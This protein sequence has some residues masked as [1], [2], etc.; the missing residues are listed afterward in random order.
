MVALSYTTA[1]TT[2]QAVIN[3]LEAGISDS[4]RVLKFADDTKL[5]RKVDSSND[6]AVLQR[7]GN[8]NEKISKI[9]RPLILPEVINR[10]LKQFTDSAET[11]KLL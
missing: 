9:G 6:Q 4:S 1:C 7:D 5:Y 10:L 2:V 3:D 8:G 11:T